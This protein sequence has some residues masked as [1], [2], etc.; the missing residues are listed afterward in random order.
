MF[1]HGLKINISLNLA[2][3]MGFAML[4]MNAVTL[5]SMQN[6]LI[7][8][9]ISRGYLLISAMESHVNAFP[10]FPNFAGRRVLLSYGPEIRCAVIL[11]IRMNEIYS[12]GNADMLKHRLIPAVRESIH[13][14]S[15]ISSSFGTKWGIFWKQRQHLVLTAPMFRD[16]K[17]I[18]RAGIVLQLEDLYT[19][20]RRTQ[21]VLFIYILINMMLLTFI[22]FHV[23]SRIVVKPVQRLLKRAGEYREDS[24]F[25]FSDGKENNEF[26]QL[27][28]ALNRMLKRI[29]ADRE[30][31]RLT[32]S[33]LE[34]A[35]S[36][37][38]RAQ[39]EIIRAEKLASVGRLSS[40]IAHEIGNPL[41]IVLGYLGLLR[42]SDISED[43]KE[44]F[45]VRAEDEINRISN[46]IRKLL[47][48]SRPSQEGKGEVS[49]HKIIR[50]IINVLEFQPF[51]SNI[52]VRLLLSAENDTVAADPDRLRQVFLNIALNAADA[53]ASLG[54]EADAELTIASEFLPEGVSEED[55]SVLKLTFADNGPGIPQK[56]ISN[57]F[58]PFYTTKEPGKGTGLGLAVSFMIIEAVGGRMEA[59]SE[60]QG[61]GTVMT[62][63]LPVSGQ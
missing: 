43:E 49:V 16:K 12:Y 24:E 26:S 46:I 23:L 14:E 39:K 29:S 27:S 47:D 30:E 21:R 42:R 62:L 3:L 2:I 54:D 53:V 4:L 58:D 32:V 34:K 18:G 31:L 36:D 57:I 6:I 11:D 1:P 52:R 41:A 7:R 5:L 63:Y 25:F 10:T 22:G 56:D 38:T 45:I 55:S 48:F 60:E 33:S 9:E 20:V 13:S 61:K 59:A 28:K 17:I 19:T 44:E 15:R 37:L 35:N 50:D 8:S 51:M 40:G